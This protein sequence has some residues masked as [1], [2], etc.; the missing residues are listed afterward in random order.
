MIS[1]FA[2]LL[3]IILPK[4]ISLHFH[5]INIVNIIFI[6]PILKYGTVASASR[7]NFD[8]L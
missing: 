4:A 1:S 2:H 6:I 8:L 3:K 5:I 7:M